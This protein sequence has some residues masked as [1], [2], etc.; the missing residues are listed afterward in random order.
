MLNPEA[1]TDTIG[2]LVH[3]NSDIK[4]SA[5]ATMYDLYGRD[6]TNDC[7]SIQYNAK[8]IYHT[9]KHSKCLKSIHSVTTKAIQRLPPKDYH[10]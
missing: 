5:Q 4:T 1:N 2:Y 3:Q 6:Q 7:T 10:S 8:F 9:L